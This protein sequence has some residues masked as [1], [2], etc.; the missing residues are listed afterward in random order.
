[1]LIIFSAFSFYPVFAYSTFADL[2]IGI[3]VNVFH[4]LYVEPGQK[5]IVGLLIRNSNLDPAEN[6]VFDVS[7]DESAI[8]MLSE[9]PIIIKT[10]GNGQS[11]IGRVLYFQ[12]EPTALPGA[13]YINFNYKHEYDINP[14]SKDFSVTFDIK[15]KP[16]VLVRSVTPEI[17]FAE[18]EFPFKI[19]ITPEQTE[20][21]DV[22]VLLIPPNEINLN[23][24]NKY[25]FP[26]IYRDSPITLDAKLALTD[27]K[28][29]DVNEYYKTF[30]IKINYTDIVGKEHSDTNDISILLHNYASPVLV[31][32]DPGISV[33]AVTSQTIFSDAT[34]P[35]TIEIMTMQSKITDA[36]FLLLPP[37]EIKFEGKK[38]YTFPSLDKNEPIIFHGKFNTFE[39]ENVDHNQYF[40]FQVMIAHNNP[41]GEN[42]VTTKTIPVLFRER[43]FFE[44]NYDGGLWAGMAFIPFVF[45]LL[46]ILAPISIAGIIITWKIKQSLQ[47][48]RKYGF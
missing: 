43:S 28:G 35:F 29:S 32:D 14:I 41:N 47:E 39:N 37:E 38:E 11:S 33:R 27:F 18:G 5:F 46:M 42:V 13:Q 30:K 36:T 20:I 44:W 25:N 24:E 9:K 8:N 10:I 48:R 3:D 19:E 2:E 12:V 4:P 21:R 45:V 23:N 26:S 16:L 1:M 15:E 17:I 31:R 7:T 40:P 34:F 6:L 22:S